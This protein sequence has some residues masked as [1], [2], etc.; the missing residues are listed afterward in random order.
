MRPNHRL[1]SSVNYNNPIRRVF[2]RLLIQDLRYGLRVLGKNPGLTLVIVLSLA[3]GIGA[4]TA[5]FS[6]AD[7]LLLKPLP[8]PH[9]D[10]LAILWQRSPGIGIPEDW[11]SPGH[12]V[13]MIQG[14]RSFE[15]M[16][17]CAGLSLTLTGRDQPER[18]DAIQTSSSLLHLL[19]A[20]PYAGRLFTTEDD[21]PGRR[22]V[23]LLTHA[24]WKRLFNSDPGMVGRNIILNGNPFAV[25]GILRPDFLLNHE[26]VPTVAGIDKADILLSYAMPADAQTKLRANDNY[27]I[28]GRLKSGVSFAQA[29]ADIDRIA[30][31]IRVADKLDPSLTISV[32]PLREQV[33]GN[34]KRSLLVLLG[35]VALVLLIACANVANL[36][37]SRATGRQK[38]IAIRTALGAGAARVVRQLL[39]ESVLLAL[40]GGAAGLGIAAIALSV[41]RA[42][43][44]GNI[45]RLETIS[46]DARVLAFT[47]AVAILTGI[48]F[49]L[50]PALRALA[51]DLNTTLKAGGRASQ[52]AGGFHIGRHRL[53]GMLVAA[54]IAF[55]MIL[56]IGASLLVRSFLRLQQVRPGFN[57]DHVISLRMALVGPKY[58]QPGATAR[59]VQEI[60]GRVSRLPGVKAAGGVSALPFTASVGWGGIQIEGYVQP[61]NEPELLADQRA[62][63]PDYFKA[64]EI[65]LI[66]GRMFDDHDT[67]DSPPVVLIDEKMAKRFWPRESAIG[68]RVRNGPQ[69]KWMTIVGVVGTVKQYG[70]DKDLRMAEYSPYAQAASGRMYLAA[71]TA[72]DPATLAASVTR[73]VHAV[74]PDAPVYEVSTMSQRIYDSLAR[75]RFSSTMLTAFAAFAMLLGGVGIYGVMSYLVTQGMHD[76]G[77]RIAL[78]ASRG[79]ILGLVVRQ[80]MTLAGAGIGAGLAGAF[81]L[82]RVI[83]ALLFQVSA[84]DIAT[85]SLVALF[86][87]GIALLASYVPAWRATRVDPLVALREE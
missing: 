60:L 70:L 43:H 69:G 67:A 75:E 71:R 63:T 7:A 45:P 29:Q 53:R 86:V 15:E 78:G 41:L 47:F 65:P 46:L 23:V 33:V 49:G 54:E 31:H 79:S 87:A 83:S 61:P 34:V 48:A 13:D 42:M 24:V 38:E 56:L 57:P 21:A 1:P 30:A 18:I 58:R 84:T 19:G 59:A 81:A 16:A 52:G 39:T 85:F 37:L 20:Q 12:Y 74:E 36:L 80:G 76:L 64:M 66:A 50:A 73:E 6:V 27:N 40:I 11:L 26:A 62:A 9:D 82:T 10:R 25:A 35:S 44:P 8:Y 2:V 51:L 14:N 77:V 55:S 32:V 68:K 3:A 5:V 28:L 72:Q 17:I 4:N 22:P